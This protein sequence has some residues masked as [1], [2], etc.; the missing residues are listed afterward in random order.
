MLSN[1][2][3]KFALWEE[4]FLPRRRRRRKERR[5]KGKYQELTSS[6]ALTN[7]VLKLMIMSTMNMISTNRSTTIKGSSPYF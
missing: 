3:G 4:H 2:K 6:V 5:E 1:G 7:V